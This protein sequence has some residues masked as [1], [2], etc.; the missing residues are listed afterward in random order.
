M[1]KKAQ[2]AVSTRVEAEGWGSMGLNVVPEMP[3]DQRVILMRNLGYP[4]G[5]HLVIAT[6]DRA[7]CILEQLSLLVDQSGNPELIAQAQ[8]WVA[9]WNAECEQ[10]FLPICLNHPGSQP[11]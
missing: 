3:L 2:V 6:Q 9:R 1:K 7:S 8:A 10:L 11:T 5:T 4:K